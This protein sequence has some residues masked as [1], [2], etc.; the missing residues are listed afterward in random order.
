[1]QR[2]QLIVWPD[3]PPGWK[4]TDRKPDMDA[5]DRAEQ[6]YRRIAALDT[7]TP[8]RL[9]FDDEAQALFEQWLTDL[10]QRIRDEGL[11]PH[12]QAHLAK[13]RSLMPTLALLFA[14]ADGRTECVPISHAQLACDWCDYLV[15]HA[16]RIYSSQAGPELQAAIALSKRLAKGWMCDE[17]VFTVRDVYRK[18]WAFLDTPDAARAALAVLEEYCWVKRETKSDPQTGGRPS[19]TYRINPRIGGKHAGN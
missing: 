11:S 13:Y 18:C 6:V 8:L 4:Y 15:T 16:N 2:F 5:V 12:M 9:Q 3:A 1:V 17:G 14:L 7:A 10:E 19:E